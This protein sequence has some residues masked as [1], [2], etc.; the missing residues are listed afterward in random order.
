M[1]NSRINHRLQILIIF[2]VALSLL[3]AGV[4][5]PDLS[6]P[7]R[8]KATQR[9]VVESQHKSIAN[10]L[11]QQNDLVSVVPT[12]VAPSNILSYQISD[13]VPPRYTSPPPPPTVGRS[14]PASKSRS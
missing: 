13:L 6:R 1:M 3:S 5:V 8:P 9:I 11:K 2:L 12:Q 7:H 14:P 10:C 4:R